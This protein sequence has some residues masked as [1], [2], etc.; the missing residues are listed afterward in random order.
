M[1][2][3]KALTLRRLASKTRETVSART[4]AAD[5]TPVA[6]SLVIPLYRVEAYLPAL[7]DSLLAQRRGAYRAELVFVDDGSPDASA[8]VVQAWLDRLDRPDFTGR[9]LSQPN[10]GV[11]SARNLGIEAAQGEWISFPDSDDYLHPKYLSA[12]ASFLTSPKGAHPQVV[13]ANIHKFLETSQEVV[14]NHSLRFKFK[15]AAKNVDLTASPH[16]VQMSAA[17]AFFR[18]DHLNEHAL[19]FTPGLHSSEDALFV[20]DVFAH[21]AKPTLG[22]VPA[23]VYYY[24]KRAAKDSAVDLYSA[25]VDTYFER[26]EQGYL[27]LLERTA[28][29]ATGLAPEWLA[30]QVLYELRWIFGKELDPHTKAPLDVEQQQRFLNNAT[31]LLAFI[32]DGAILGY[33]VT[34]V[35]SQIR[36]L[37]LELKGSALP[38]PRVHV[39]RL[40]ASSQQL[41]LRYLYRGDAPTEEFRVR[42]KVVEPLHAKTALVDFFGQRRLFERVVWLPATSWLAVK[43]DGVTEELGLGE[44]AR[45]PYALTEVEIWRH[46]GEAS[47]AG[48]PF[49]QP[50]S[51]IA[52]GQPSAEQAARRAVQL[53]RRFADA[54]VLTDAPDHAQGPSE[55]LYRWLRQHRRD[56]NA[57]FLLRKGSPDWA[58]L[59]AE[60]FR[61]IDDGR[62]AKLPA[63][64]NAGQLIVSSADPAALSP[65]PT[66]YFPAT[67]RPWRLVYL[68]DPQG[69]PLTAQEATQR[70]VD[71]WCVTEEEQA[72]ALVGDFTPGLLTTREVAV[73]NP[74]SANGEVP[75]AIVEAIEARSTPVAKV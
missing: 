45:K 2:D 71:L 58:R 1:S 65:I 61:L 5:V 40:D 3:R 36:M 53:R 69:R 57:W 6:L 15:G 23:A 34:T 30:N 11:G 56:V 50:R 68:A 35:P 12:I 33:R 37:W 70:Q 48:K 32:S 64:L 38:S 49:P 54:W 66:G 52:P 67:G 62:A 42:A 29:P 24:R 20:S 8:A 47:V 7:L 75:A 25:R 13:A 51:D 16:Y 43:L 26:F 27:P 46:F 21:S 39:T 63:L 41:Q 44:P 22:V 14:D 19:R 18:A 17:T 55:A 10:S 4:A 72:E 74:T 60:G 28:D 9:L 59:K 73:I 31:A